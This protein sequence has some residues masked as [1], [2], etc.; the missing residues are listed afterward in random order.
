LIQG[1]KFMRKKL[2]IPLLGAIVLAPAAWAND[3]HHASTG[4]TA[5]EQA[6]GFAANEG[7]IRKV[8]KAQG[9][10]TIKHGPLPEVDMSSM[11]MIFRV[12]DP[13][14][15]E[16]VTAGDKVK[17]RAGKVDGVLT[18]MQLERMN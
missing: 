5:A 6:S 2:L 4:D 14:M 16:Q 17:L 7:E 9:K 10:L 13:A 3:A 18:V 15:L 1:E 11:T 12:K 8:D